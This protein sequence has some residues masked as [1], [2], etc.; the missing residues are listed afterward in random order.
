M[1]ILKEQDIRPVQF[2]TKQGIASLTDLG[3]ILSKSSEFVEVDCPACGVNDHF[4]KFKKN[5]INYVEC[6]RCR[7]FYVN[8]RPSSDVLEWFYRG[9][10]NYAYWNEV[11]FPATESARLERIFI[12]RVDRLLELC[13]KYDVE[14]NS[15][16]EVGAGF[17]TFCAELKRRN[18]FSRIV[19]VEPTP[20]LAKTCRERD[21]SILEMPVEKVQMNAGELFD[22]V[23]SF[24][25]IEHLFE[26]VAFIRHMT[27]LLKRGGILMLSCPNGQGFDIETLG[28]ASNT[29]EHE[30]LNYFNR[31][32]LAE[33]LARCGLEI[34]E[35]FTPGQLDADLVRN[36]ILTGEFDVT[37]QPFLKKILIDDWDHLGAPFQDFLMRQGLSSNM[38]IVARKLRNN[39]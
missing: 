18:I 33:M 8:P 14:T 29:V 5:G 36:K 6:K 2:M 10:P 39:S 3:R 30:H 38:W 4:P 19:G 20:D 15:I 16:L 21:I 12:P 26:P 22:V 7:T 24:E 32:S 37:N 11:I 25:V 23:A 13:R 27:R 34:L 9:S 31:Q 17:G 28:V 35:S 1:A